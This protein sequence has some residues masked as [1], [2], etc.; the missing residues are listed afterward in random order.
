[1]TGSV[2]WVGGGLAGR[3]GCV[4]E[5]EGCLRL[6]VRLARSEEV[7]TVIVVELSS[8]GDGPGVKTER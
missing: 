4:V 1:M 3:A 2:R 7:R 6:S 5:G 8:C